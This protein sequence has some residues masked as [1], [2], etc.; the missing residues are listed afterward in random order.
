M[1]PENRQRWKKSPLSEKISNASEP[2]CRIVVFSLVTP[3]TQPSNR[4]PSGRMRT[5]LERP[6]V[7]PNRL[8]SLQKPASCRLLFCPS[9]G[10]GGHDR[11]KR[12]EG[13]QQPPAGDPFGEGH[14]PASAC[15]DGHSDHQASRPSGTEAPCRF[16]EDRGHC[17]RR[18]DGND[19][20]PPALM[21]AS[22]MGARCSAHAP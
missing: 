2:I 20:D 1:R 15:C 18:H 16:L 10:R 7:P 4:P 9:H 12:V 6:I 8:S 21:F 13:G 17:D 3:R 19:A 14:F 11:L 5:K 22:R